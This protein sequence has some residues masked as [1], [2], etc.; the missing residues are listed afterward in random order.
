MKDLPFFV[1]G[2]D[3]PSPSVRSPEATY[4]FDIAKTT[5]REALAT[6]ITR[7]RYSDREPTGSASCRTRGE[8]LPRDDRPG[9]PGAIVL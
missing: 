9:I 8:R 5:T 6:P 2:P 7:R 1:C 4:R 3:H